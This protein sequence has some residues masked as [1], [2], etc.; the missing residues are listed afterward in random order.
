MTTTTASLTF[1]NSSDALFRAWASGISNA[2]GTVGLVKTGDTGQI[3]FS[4]V[5]RPTANSQAMGYEIWRFNDSLQATRPVYFKIEYGA[6]VA[7]VAGAPPGIWL[8]VGTGSNGAGT[9]TGAP[10][11]ATRRLYTNAASQTYTTGT[12][13]CYFASNTG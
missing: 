7:S 13:T 5:A 10:I 1:D 12:V 2:L 9:I 4:S 8:T 3:D 11:I 6:G